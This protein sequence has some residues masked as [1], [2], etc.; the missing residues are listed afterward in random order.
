M[1]R[2]LDVLLLVFGLAWGSNVGRPA[3]ASTFVEV[4]LADLVRVSSLIVVGT[5]AEQTSVWEDTDAGHSRRIV[6]YT[7]VRVDTV[8]DGTPPAAPDVWVR[9]LGGQVGDIGQRVDG[10]AVLVPMQSSLMFLRARADGT[11]AVTAMAQGHFP[12]RVVD[13]GGPPRI[14]ISPAAGRLIPPVG[15]PRPARIVLDAMTLDEAAHVIE[16]ERRVRAR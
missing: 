2:R 15:A 16:G 5:A 12:V 1:R 8:V 11:H 14:T 13:A 4:S 6:T 10:E 7:R 3:L 9:T